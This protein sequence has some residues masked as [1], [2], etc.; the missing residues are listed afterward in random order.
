MAEI[1]NENLRTIEMLLNTTISNLLYG[2]STD[3]G[4]SECAAAAACFRTLKL[5]SLPIKD[6]ENVMKQLT[7]PTENISEYNFLK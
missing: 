2:G 7:N 1:A 4:W 3:A 6:E 5:L